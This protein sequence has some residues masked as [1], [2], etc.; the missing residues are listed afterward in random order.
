MLVISKIL[1]NLWNVEEKK[2]EGENSHQYGSH[3]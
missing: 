3:Q 1:R 2:S